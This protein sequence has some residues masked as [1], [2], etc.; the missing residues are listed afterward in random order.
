MT[1]DISPLCIWF[2]GLSGAGKTTLA[3]ALDAQ[4]RAQGVRTLLLDGDALRTGLNSDLG[5]S[6]AD[7]SENIRRMA[8]VARLMVDAGLVVLVSAI[9]PY[10]QGR[11]F[12]RQRMG[13]GRFVEVFVDAPLAECQ[14]RDPHS[15]RR[16]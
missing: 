13:E 8:E 15:Y 14:R 6:E 5:F 12:A 9:S 4:L 1:P 11:D 7:R 3:R 2:T 10:A 16:F